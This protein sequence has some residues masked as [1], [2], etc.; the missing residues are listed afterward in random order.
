MTNA[1]L[2]PCENCFNQLVD[3]RFDTICDGCRE[4]LHQEARLRDKKEKAARDKAASQVFF[5]TPVFVPPS[6]DAYAYESPSNMRFTTTCMGCNKKNVGDPCPDCRE[7]LVQYEREFAAANQA[8]MRQDAYRSTGMV[9]AK[10]YEELQDGL[11]ASRRQVKDAHKQIEDL[12]SGIKELQEW[13]E[14]NFNKS[15]AE[16]KNYPPEA[17]GYAILCAL[18]EVYAQMSEHCAATLE[19]NE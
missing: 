12:K 5:N 3:L 11:M 1:P 18:K 4:C 6:A 14:E 2:R 13:S 17:K 7:H 15:L 8:A 16:L 9:S 10:K 19:D